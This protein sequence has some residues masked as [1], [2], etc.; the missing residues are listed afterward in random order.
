MKFNIERPKNS[1]RIVVRLRLQTKVTLVTPQIHGSDPYI[2]VSPRVSRTRPCT[3]NI[4][5]KQT[6]VLRQ[7][8]KKT[9][10]VSRQS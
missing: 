2:R 3:S 9:A 4:V 8:F 5:V 6:D 1:I 7:V 10:I